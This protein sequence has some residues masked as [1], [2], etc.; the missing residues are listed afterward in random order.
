MNQ[1]LDRGIQAAEQ[2]G[3]EHA[4][5]DFRLMRAVGNAREGDVGRALDL[6]QGV[7]L[8]PHAQDLSI[9]LTPRDGSITATMIQL[10]DIFYEYG[11]NQEAKHFY[12]EA[13]ER[14]EQ[15][16]VLLT[17]GP[18]A[19]NR[20]SQGWEIVVP[21]QSPKMLAIRG[22]TS[23][24]MHRKRLETA[25]TRLHDTLATVKG[26]QNPNQKSESNKAFSKYSGRIYTADQDSISGRLI[27]G[28]WSG[29]KHSGPISEA[30]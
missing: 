20:T 6:I 16:G 19:T 5:L 21:Q 12:G 9:T 4:L 17:H 7:Q 15:L 18:E 26:T 24:G 14:V 10:G 23:V 3:D 13:R 30:D 2:T 22:A 11:R 27:G 28:G 25:V 8:P 1:W 29:G